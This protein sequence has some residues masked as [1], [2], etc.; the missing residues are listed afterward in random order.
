[1]QYLHARYKTCHLTQGNL[2]CLMKWGCRGHWGHW[3]YWGYRGYR[4]C[5]GYKACKITT[6]NFSVI[7]VLKFGLTLMF[8]RKKIGVESEISCWI[9]APFLSEAVE[10]S[11]KKFV[12]TTSLNNFYS[13]WNIMKHVQDRAQLDWTYEFPDRTGLDPTRLNPDLYF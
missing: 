9:L 3:V 4:G 5:R 10:A 8:W 6:L 7:Q 13:H 12:E 1:M 2:N 11:K